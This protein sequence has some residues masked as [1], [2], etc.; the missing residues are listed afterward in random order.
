MDIMIQDTETQLAYALH[1]DDA[2]Y[3]GMD[4]EFVEFE[5]EYD[6]ELVN[7]LTHIEGDYDS[8][9]F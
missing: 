8:F 2:L 5:N 9:M 7:F 1:H 4:D 6:D 3:L